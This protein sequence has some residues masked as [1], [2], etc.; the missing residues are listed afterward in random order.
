MEKSSCA[1]TGHR[2]ERFAFGY[3]EN[4]ER[5]LRIKSAMS[6]WITALII[7]G[8]RTFYTGMALGVDQWA[9]S[10]VLDMKQQYS[11]VRLIALIPCK[12]QA[13]KWSEEQRERYKTIIADCDGVEILNDHYIRGCMHQRN[14]MLVERAAYLLAVYDGGEEGGTA[15][16]VNYARKNNRQITIIHPDTLTVDSSTDTD[17]LRRRGEIRLSKEK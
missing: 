10:I 17:T 2:P 3:D 11:G 6:E 4:D 1:F 8:V 7:G 9:A 15:Y 16:T 5:C 13:D 14:R 12:T